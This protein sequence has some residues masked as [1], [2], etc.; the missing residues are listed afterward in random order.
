MTES[1]PAKFSAPDAEI[2]EALGVALAPLLRP[3]DAVCLVGPLGAGKTTFV[4]G[5]GRG[6]D[7]ADPVA[8]PTFVIARRH[9]G[10]RVD[11]LH[12]DAYRVAGPGE[13][14]DLDL[15]TEGVVTVVEWGQ[16]V[17]AEICDSWLEIEFDRG[18]GGDEQ[19]R[20]MAARGH[21]SRWGSSELAALDREWQSVLS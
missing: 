8:S 11:L 14:A 1:L 7:V 17:M 9:R 10:P 13:F 2:T 19:G 5:L 21:G 15:D 12:C 18:E 20:V 4:R 3:G 16:S 6:L